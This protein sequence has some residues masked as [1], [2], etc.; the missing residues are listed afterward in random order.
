MNKYVYAKE[1]ELGLP[2]KAEVTQDSSNEVLA[3]KG[4]GGGREEWKLSLN[5]M[6]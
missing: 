2:R 1:L 4:W 6:A 3:L 5:I